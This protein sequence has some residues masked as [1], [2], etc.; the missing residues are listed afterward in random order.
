[1]AETIFNIDSYIEDLKT[2][3]KQAAAKKVAA[4]AE[5]KQKKSESNAAK[6][7]RAEANNKFQYA[8][9]L[10]K[11][12]IDFEGQLKSYGTKIARGDV[13]TAIEQRDFDYAVKQYKS[14]ST[15]YTTALNEGNA[16]LAKMPAGYAEGPTGPTGA[17]GGTGTTGATGATTS[18][19]TTTVG[20]TDFLKGFVGNTEKIKQLQ[21]ALFNTGEYKGPIDGILRAD[22][23]IPAAERA[24][25][26][27]GQYTA[28]GMPF[29]DRF[30]G[31]KRLQPTGG[32]GG[33]GAPTTT[34]S[35]R[36]TATTYIDAALKS[37]G[38]NRDATPEEIDNLTKVLNDAE[39]RFKTTTKKGVTRDLLGNRQQFIEN[40]ITT[41]K[42]VDPNTG[43]PIKGVKE[44]VKKAAAVLGTL[45]KS[46]QGLKADTRSLSVQTLRST[47]N[48]N[49]V[50]LSQQQLDQYA[51]DIQN[52]KDIKVIQS[53]IR[54]IAGAGMPDNV[55]KL[56]AEGT[57]LETVYAPYRTQMA[58]IL[59]VNPETINFTDPA[60]RNAIGPNGEMSIYDFQRALRKDAR[61]Q[62]TNNAREDVFQ[63]V[64]KVLQDFGFQ[65]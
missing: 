35:P 31:Y 29:V 43:K 4:E 15:A 1:M 60:L 3:Q 56:L 52:G 33:A 40:L 53:Q 34:I 61:W 20:L 23:I 7:V 39:S 21:Q 27:L 8:E 17:T 58:A 63:S 26:R 11:T 37:L 18:I 49:G 32:A 47:A 51:L 57:D 24:E 5:A 30:E 59:E 14:V 22:V 2:A 50:S 48:A 16:I 55:K 65:G 6:R 36:A 25:E 46:V 28:L 10:G 45:S 42:Y 62:Y 19:A 9:G 44:D 13:L 38:I 64:G 12:L 54:N 41:G